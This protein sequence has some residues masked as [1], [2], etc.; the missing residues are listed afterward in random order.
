MAPLSSSPVRQVT[1]VL[2]AV[3]EER[4]PLVGLD[5]R[6]GVFLGVAAGE[7]D[8]GYQLGIVVHRHVSAA[9]QPQ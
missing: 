8:V 1:D 4:D 2:A 5:K 9:G 7:Q 6:S 3:G